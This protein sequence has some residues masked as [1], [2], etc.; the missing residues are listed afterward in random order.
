M[1]GELTHSFGTPKNRW[2]TTASTSWM[3]ELSARTRRMFIRTFAKGWN[4]GKVEEQMTTFKTTG[5]CSRALEQ[6]GKAVV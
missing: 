6:S 5:T 4:D 3:V 2:N 1:H